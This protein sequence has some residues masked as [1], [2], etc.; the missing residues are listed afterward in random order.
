MDI[1]AM[2]RRYCLY[3]LVLKAI[4]CNTFA[5]LYLLGLKTPMNAR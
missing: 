1:D 5:S 3:Q 2:K 4:T